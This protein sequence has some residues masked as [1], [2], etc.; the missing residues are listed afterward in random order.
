[1]VAVVAYVAGYAILTGVLLVVA[2]LRQ[3]RW[4]AALDRVAVIGAS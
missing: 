3:R 1:V 4:R 2:S